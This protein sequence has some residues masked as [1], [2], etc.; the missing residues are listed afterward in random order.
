MRPVPPPEAFQGTDAAAGAVPPPL[1]VRRYKR[2]KMREADW[3][4]ADILMVTDGEIPN[5]KPTLKEDL[6]KAIEEQ[7]LRLHALLVGN[8][9]SKAIEQLCTDVH[10]FKDWKQAEKRVRIS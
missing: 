9:T 5:A 2:E 3:S 6:D 10:L 8:R 7:G 1:P 4:R